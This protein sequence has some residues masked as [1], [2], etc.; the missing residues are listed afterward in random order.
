MKGRPTKVPQDL[1]E[2]QT[3]LIWSNR[4]FYYKRVETYKMYCAKFYDTHMY[5]TENKQ[6]C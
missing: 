1:S 2:N 5:T 4:L 3:V 6:K